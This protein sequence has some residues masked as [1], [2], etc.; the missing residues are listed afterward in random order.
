MGIRWRCVGS[1]RRICGAIL[2]PGSVSGAP[3]LV[4]FALLL[5]LRLQPM[6]RGF[7][8]LAIEAY[9]TNACVTGAYRTVEDC[10]IEDGPVLSGDPG[11][12]SILYALQ[13]RAG[14]SDKGPCFYTS[15]RSPSGTEL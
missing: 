8:Y 3:F 13:S 10:L 7:D 9:G 5:L 11:G 12:S 6:H 15:P 1:A 4:L 14:V 2:D